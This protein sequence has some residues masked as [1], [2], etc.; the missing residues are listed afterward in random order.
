MK[1]L[2]TKATQRLCALAAMVVLTAA[3]PTAHAGPA[4]APQVNREGGVT[5]KVTPLELSPLA[6]EWRFAVVLDT[7]VSALDQDMTAVTTLAGGKGR[8]LRPRAWEGDKPGGHHRKG[9]LK[10]DAI[11]PAPASVTLTIRNVGGAPERRFNWT[12]PAQ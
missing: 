9:V 12:V 1:S 11:R 3:M 2:R 5:V 6:A 10:F 8:E 4:L 7:H